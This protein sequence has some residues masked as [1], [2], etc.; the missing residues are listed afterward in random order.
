MSQPLYRTTAVIWTSENADGWDIHRLAYES[1]TGCGVCIET[2]TEVIDYP[3]D[4]P[5]W[6]DDL[7]EFFEIEGYHDWE[8]HGCGF[9]LRVAEIRETCIQNQTYNIT[10]DFQT[11][12]FSATAEDSYD[13]DGCQYACGK[14]GCIVT[15]D[16]R[17]EIMNRE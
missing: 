13:V 10:Y 15:D 11:K 17:N 7:A 16:Q 3:R 14:C 6:T 8:C 9:D 12:M 4:H 1:D 5:E 2:S